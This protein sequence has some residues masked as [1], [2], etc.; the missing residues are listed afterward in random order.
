MEAGLGYWL[1]L[2]ESGELLY[3]GFTGVTG[4]R[5]RTPRPI[6]HRNPDP[7]RT[8]V[9]L[10]GANVTV[11][12]VS[13]PGTP[14]LEAVSPE[15]V[16]CGRGLLHDG[17][18]RMMPVYGFDE[19]TPASSGYP[20]PGETVN[21]RFE[22]EPLRETLTWTKRGDRLHLGDLHRLQSNNLPTAFELHQNYPNPFNPGTVI[23]FDLPRNT[24][25]ELSVFNILG[26][27][28]ATLVN[29]PVTAGQHQIVWDGCNDSGA[30]VSSGVYLYRLKT[31]ARAVTRRMVLMK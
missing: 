21:L 3:P 12:G 24:R 29:G 30:A 14:R 10:Y 15:G 22:G 2:S 26:Q 23:C 20:K 7:S 18:L 1:K 5:K 31:P 13:P 16:V 9:S 27:R 6:I 28:V 8:W 17:R 11:D 4:G 19:A 25:V